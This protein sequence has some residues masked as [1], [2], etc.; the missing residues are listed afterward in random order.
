MQT[1]KNK[2][3][4]ITGGAGFIGSYVNKLLNQEGYRTIVI[5]NLSRG[6]R[7]T[8]RYG[9]FIE[10]DCGNGNLL[11]QIFKQYEIDTVIHFAAFID[12]GESVINPTKY[13]NNNVSQ[14]L[15]LLEKMVQYKIPHFLFSSTA[16][17]YGHPKKIPLTEQHPCEPINPYGESK[18]MVEK[19]AADISRA[20]GLKCCFLRYFNAAGGDP[21]GEI[22]NHQTKPNNLIPIVLRCLKNQT[23]LTVF[24]G[25]YKTA[26]GTC[27]RDYIHLHDLAIAHLLA[28]EQ[29]NNS[30]SS[31]LIYNLGTGKGFSVLEIINAAEKATGIKLNYQIG[32]RR[33]GDPPILIADSQKAQK[34]LDWKA[35]LSDPMT[36]IRDAWKTLL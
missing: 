2:A 5:D 1:S 21:D 12:V 7:E 30:S 3:V 14:S 36:I 10:G 25:D 20:Y 6:F 16:A 9:H 24:G 23:P 26:D 28:M 8:I 33:P 27:V 34:E 15:S 29:L 22:K 18:W 13:Y 31:P 11:D 17:I 4:V 19:I 35:Q 32:E